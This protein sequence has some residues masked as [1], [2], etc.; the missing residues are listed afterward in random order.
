MALGDFIARVSD[1]LNKGSSLDPLIP[2]RIRDTVKYLESN[3]TW[4]HMERFVSFTLTG[5]SMNV[6]S[7]M[8][9]M[10]FLRHVGVDGYRYLTRVNPRD[11]E[12]TGTGAPTGYWYDGR[13]YIWFDNTPDEALTMEMSYIERTAWGTDDAFTHFFLEAGEPV[14]FAGTMQRMALRARE[15]ELAQ[16]YAAQFQLDLAA[17]LKAEAEFE[18]ENSDARMVYE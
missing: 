5:R 7:R 10:R 17:L 15:P 11:V 13:D 12:R 18:F 2:A 3:S 8:K 14:L 1:E 16:V 9:A 4:K 6:P